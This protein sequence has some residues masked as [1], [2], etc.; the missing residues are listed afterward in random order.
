MAEDRTHA[1]YVVAQMGSRL[2][3]SVPRSLHAAR[4]LERLYTDICASKGI[5]SWFRLLPPS[6]QPNRLKKLLGRTPRGIPQHKV[7]DF[8]QQAFRARASRKKAMSRAAIVAHNHETARAFCRSV[9]EAGLGSASGVY[10]FKSAALEIFQLARSLGLCTVLDQTGA[11]TESYWRMSAEEEKR[12]PDWQARGALGTS[13]LE[14]YCERERRERELA[15]IIL[16][17]SHYVI[18]SLLPGGVEAGKCRLVPYGYDSL[19]TDT[20]RETGTLHRR[21]M[22]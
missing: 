20:P 11:L 12:Y 13:E 19:R 16:C 14:A 7:M 10:A 15:D 2:H 18:T 3:Y 4:R 8:K 1:R 6:L 9:V 21:C 17:P 5:I 22:F